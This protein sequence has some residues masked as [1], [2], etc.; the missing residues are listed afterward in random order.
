M[1]K[2]LE[3][4]RQINKKYDNSAKKAFDRVLTPKKAATTLDDSPL[5]AAV[6]KVAEAM[7]IAVKIPPLRKLSG[8]DPFKLIADESGFRFRLVEL[9]ADWYKNDNGPMLAFTA[10]GEPVALIPQSPNRYRCWSVDKKPQE[11]DAESEFPRA[12]VF[13]PPLPKEPVSFFDMVKLGIKLF[14]RRDLI[15][16]LVLAV[17]TALLSLL[18]AMAMQE[19]FNVWI[20]QNQSVTIWVVGFILVAVAIS[21]GL[22]TMVQNISVL[23]IQGKLSILQNSLL[24]K[25]LS[26]PASFFKQYSSGALAMRATGFAMIQKILSVNVITM[27]ITS[28]FSIINGLYIF[29]ISPTIGLLAMGLTAISVAITLVIGKMQMKCQRASLEMS[30]DISGM[31]FELI[32]SVSRLRVAGAESRSYLKWVRAYAK[33]RKVEYKR[34]QL[35]ALLRLTTIALPTLSMCVIYYYVSVN[36]ISSGGFVAINSAFMIFISSLLGLVQTLISINSVVPQY[37]NTKPIINGVP[38]VDSFKT[39]P[40]IIQGDIEINHLYFSYY[41]GGATILDNICFNIKHGEY[42]AIVGASGSGKSTLLRLLLGFEKPTSGSIY[43]GGFDLES[44][45]I[46]EIRKQMGVVLQDSQLI[47]GDILSNIAGSKKELTEDDVWE[48]LKKVGM[49]EEIRQMPM[50]LKTMVAEGAGTLSGGQRQKLLIA[51]AIAASPAIIFFDEATSALDNR[52]QQIVSASM[53]NL[54]ATRIVIAHRLSTIMNCDRILVLEK[55]NI[56]EEGT[57]NELMKKEAYFYKYAKRQLV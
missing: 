36:G 43:C 15:W 16:T 9:K 7:G 29:T 32:T 38:E 8:G 40:G 30:N 5:I 54:D 12:Y 49:D 33:Q 17:V 18:P 57:Y 19:T 50:G 34:G 22:F 46:R 37:E 27:I 28:S 47:P 21:R 1:A 48:L 10:A 25:L 23:R 42:V 51:R 3:E 35:M 41:E 55:G 24:D 14:S 52:S 44:V 31:V 45:D 39:T 56:V 6:S 13:Y 26:L 4:I 2:K 53:K 20:P 11:V